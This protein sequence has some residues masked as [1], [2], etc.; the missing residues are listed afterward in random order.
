MR[1]SS[2]QPQRP[3]LYVENTHLWQ[4]K[5]RGRAAQGRVCGNEARESPRKEA[6]KRRGH[7]GIAGEQSQGGR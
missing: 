3:R 4:M 5:S 6:D 2:T 7:F 1:S